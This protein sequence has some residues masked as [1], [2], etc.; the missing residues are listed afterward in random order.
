MIALFPDLAE[1]LRGV[2]E[3]I[4]E[5]L[6]SEEPRVAALI[7]EIG[8]FHGKMLRPTL[9]LLCAEALGGADR[10]HH[11]LAAALELIH[12]ATLVH[13]DLIDDA[14]TRRGLPTLHL[15]FDNTTAVLIGDFLYTR[16]FTL[17][18]SLGDAALLA[19]LCQATN[20]VCEG[21]LHQQMAARDLTVDEAEY[22]RIAYGKT[23]ALTELA[24][25]FGAIAGDAAQ[26][27]AC[28]A[29]GRDLGLAFQIVDDCL[30]LTGDA[31]RVGKTLST[32]LARGRMTLPIIR[33]LAAA[34]A[35][36][37]AALSARWQ[38]AETPEALAEVRRLVV[39]LGGVDS[40][41]ATARALAEGAVGR[42]EVLPDTPAREH[43]ARLACAVVDRDR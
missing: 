11:R 27:A 4:E 9:C 40:A 35:Q 24:G 16:A 36:Q 13:D 18:A 5:A 2:A 3:A 29:F 34:S 6:R 31:A 10:R 7:A 41:W 8:S 22:R 28:A 43:L 25:W 30:D 32:D 12:T 23:A 19:R 15:R 38:G 21:E 37:R 33:A 14:D 1:H 26:R 39:E 17:A 42:L 20:A